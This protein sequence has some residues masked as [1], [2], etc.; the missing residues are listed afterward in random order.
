MKPK[1][2]EA[3]FKAPKHSLAAGKP[4]AKSGAAQ[5]V[6]TGKMDLGAIIAAAESLKAAGSVDAS[7]ELYETWI[8]NT[9]SPL[10]YVAIF[11]RAVT[12]AQLGRDAEAAAAYQ[13]ALDLKGDFPEA[14]VNLGLTLEK[15]GDPKGA[16]A[17]WKIVADT[18][19][20]PPA[21]LTTALN[22]TGRLLEETREY[23]TA[24]EA[25]AKS[26]RVNSKQPDALQHW[27]H[28]RQKQ[29]KWPVY[30]EL[31]GISKADML[32][33]TS[34]LAMLAEAD[35]PAL[36]LLAAQSF[37]HRKLAY[38]EG[39][40]SEGRRYNHRRLR[41]GYLSSDFCVHAVGLL[42]A[43]LF[44]N[45][46]RS[47][48]E[49]FGFCVSKEDGS[50]HRQRI[51]AALE[52]FE[53][54][55]HLSDE[56]IAR[57]VLECEIDILVDLNGLSSG[58]RV[59]VLG[60][61]PAPIQATWLGFIGTTSLP[62]I[63]FVIADAFAIPPDLA[64]YYRE[65]PMQLPHSFLPSDSRRETGTATN[66][67]EHN[68]PEDKFVFASFNNIYKL[69]PRMF[70][71][72]TDILKR[73][74]NSVLW[75]L[76]D[77]R[78]AT[79]N[80]TAFVKSRGVDPARLIFAG[81]VD[82]RLHLARLPLA[83]LFLDNH[84]YN[85]GST[86]HDVL[87]QGLPLL[88]LSGR[89]FVS[90]MGG[91]LLTA[92]GI[93]ELI[94][95]SHDEYADR[96][97]ELATQAERVAELRKHLI[98]KRN[99]GSAPSAKQFAHNLEQLFSRAAGREVTASEAPKR[100]KSNANERSLLVRGWRDINH[101]F[102]M[103]N[104]FQLIQLLKKPDLYVSHEDLP[105]HSPNW[106]PSQN[107]VGF[108]SET[109]A[110]LTSIPSHDGEPADVVLNISSPFSFYRGPAK[111]VVTFMVTEFGLDKGSFAADC[112]SSAAFS[113]GR[114][115]VVTPSRWAKH[116]LELAGIDSS[117]IAVIPHG[118]DRRIFRPPTSQERDLGRSQLGLAPGEFAFL[119]VGGAFWNKGG[120]L[121][122]RAFAEIRR[123]R[124]HVKLVLKD[125]R[126]LYG[127]TT[128]DLV[129]GLQ[130]THPG[131]LTP[132]I[133]QGV[134]VL[135]TALSMEQLRLLYGAVDA[136]A[137]P[138][139]A[140]GFNLPV[141][142]SMACGLKVLVTEGGATD[143]FFFPEVC[144]GIKSTFTDHTK[145][146]V[147][148]KGDYLEPDFD[149]LKE[150]MLRAVDAGNA[151]KN[152]VSPALDA[153]L[154]T[155][156]WEVVT[157]KLYAFLFDG[158]PNEY[159][160]LEKQPSLPTSETTSNRSLHIYCDGGFGNRFNGLVSGLVFAESAGLKPIIVWPINNWC[161]AR[162]SD[163]F[164]N[165]EFEV[166][167]KELLEYSQEKDKLHFFMTEDHLK[168]GVPFQSP[169]A[170]SSLSDA[171]H[172][173]KSDQRDV[174]YHSPL[175]PP[176]LE[177]DRVK[178]V[179]RNLRIQS[180]I[181]QRAEQFIR[182]KRLSDGFFGIQIRKTDFGAN[183][184]DDNQLL[185]LVK[186][187]NDKMFFVCSDDKTVEQKFAALKNVAIYEKQAYVEKRISGD[188]TELTA[189]H[190]GRVYPCNVHRSAESVLE[191]VTD[192][193]I[194]SRSQVIKTS[195]STFLNTALL[196]QA[197]RA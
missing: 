155:M 74:P 15:R 188:W 11:N 2:Q 50:A 62:S 75:L 53:R 160:I 104:Q 118:V 125:N 71:T 37:V 183:G 3:A 138:Y 5:S 58:T 178:P 152:A 139:R 85:A 83:D 126:S 135:P 157:E 42:L 1:I 39:H 196:L 173:L 24:E 189:D 171:V 35:D 33:A 38:P 144:T 40:L 81:R 108:D 127:R 154:N 192:L 164:E 153:F 97:V 187:A 185:D 65:K 25:L 89:T 18:A 47:K 165:S 161:S 100:I 69:N 179:I 116:K 169:L 124:P 142:E 56:Q 162:F 68:L 91:S 109:A 194:L 8:K 63:D 48:F 22:H 55:G 132:E 70:E 79:A 86:A 101:S 168:L 163:I 57:R 41:I 141:L 113:E 110:K 140:E 103:V 60:H 111:K 149:D 123:E 147:A 76:D 182:A 146:G 129:S 172:F 90:R 121:L 96:A 27:V 59:G 98:A 87:S 29:C 88:T 133:L 148:S 49:T 102:S 106:S 92:L 145:S 73:V 21:M 170:I 95:H 9:D 128:D 134:V 176:Y 159:S 7:I 64:S 150:K 66:R 23:E 45:H 28:L 151:N 52:H 72:W 80:L 122:L 93:P 186:K 13:A 107:S 4:N 54:V 20:T 180:A 31:P 115:W 195:N 197:A 77:N 156:S 10:K 14:R 131:L 167:E 158:L 177:W 46:D 117:R 82:P 94:T 12:L 19:S 136:Y 6:G 26:L 30:S 16:L 36:Q 143:D 190:S 175:I 130:A 32:L 137:S 105:Y 174:Y 17:H 114:N 184:A 84:P 99:G 120:D 191:A 44:E 166:I 34:P 43:E 78:W 193:L 181:S 61:R 119:N 51:I 112:D 67:A